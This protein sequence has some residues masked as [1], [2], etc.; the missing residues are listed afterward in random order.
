MLA[1]VG[2]IYLIVNCI[3][4][5]FHEVR[6][7]LRSR[8]H[9]E[10]QVLEVVRRNYV[11]RCF[12]R[13]RVAGAASEEALFADGGESGFAGVPVENFA[14]ETGRYHSNDSLGATSMVG[15][16]VLRSKVQTLM[17]V[18]R[19]LRRSALL[20]DTALPLAT[21]P[22]VASS[23]PLPAGKSEI[24]PLVLTTQPFLCHGRC[25]A[26]ARGCM[27]ARPVVGWPQGQSSSSLTT[28]RWAR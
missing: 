3:K 23:P 20:A 10:H 22:R 11:W 15:Y 7:A 26:T 6:F 17:G 18:R 14:A 16:D 28:K 9:S 4:Q 19:T 27:R 13:Q 1:G 8:L 24:A 25:R 21:N 5:S 2:C 12:L